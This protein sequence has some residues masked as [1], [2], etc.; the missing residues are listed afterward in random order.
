MG[1]SSGVMKAIGYAFGGAV[2]ASLLVLLLG[3]CV[4]GSQI[5]HWAE[6]QGR[7]VGT[8]GTI[9]GAAGAAR[10]VRGF[11]RAAGRGSQVT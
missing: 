10:L 4:F 11:A 8:A 1:S 2:S 5:T 7:I 6:W 3:L 9:G